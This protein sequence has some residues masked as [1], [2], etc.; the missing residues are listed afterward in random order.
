MCILF[1]NAADPLENPVQFEKTKTALAALE[2]KVCDYT[3]HPQRHA[4]LPLKKESSVFLKDGSLLV[5]FEEMQS[6]GR[7]LYVVD[8]IVQCINMGSGRRKKDAKFST[9]P[10][11]NVTHKFRP[12]LKIQNQALKAESKKTRMF[13]LDVIALE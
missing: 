5:T 4:V 11:L 10:T 1:R 13:M 3:A 8:L 2:E 6:R 7:A 9:E 12:S